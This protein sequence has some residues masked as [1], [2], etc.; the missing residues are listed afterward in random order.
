MALEYADYIASEN[1]LQML[2]LY[3]FKLGSNVVYRYCSTVNAV[4]CAG[5]NWEPESIA[6]GAI[7][8]SGSLDRQPLDI[9]VPVSNFIAQALLAAKLGG[10]VGV[11]IYRAQFGT[12]EHSQIWAGE[13]ISCSYLGEGLSTITCSPR[14][15]TLTIAPTRRKY[16]P[17]CTHALYG[18]TGCTVPPQL[19]TET[20]KVKQIVDSV[21]VTVETTGVEVG[22]TSDDILGGIF[23]VTLP[24]GTTVERAIVDV[25]DVGSRTYQL[26]LLTYIVGIAVDMQAAITRGCDHTFTTC[27][28]RF[29]NSVN[30]GGCPNIPNEDPMRSNTY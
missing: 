24:D 3:E 27:R 18:E 28:D 13:A 9:S 1:D 16:Q 25:Q 20:G 2:F 11:S 23:T 30:F 12:D 29:A 26:Q 7:T 17:G 8:A 4:F 21:T 19:H 15:K 22:L 14:V 6:H 10:P 5:R